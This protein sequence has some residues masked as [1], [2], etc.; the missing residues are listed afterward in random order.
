MRILVTGSDGPGGV[1]ATQLHNAGH[2]IVL[3]ENRRRAF[4]LDRH[5]LV[6]RSDLGNYRGAIR[7]VEAAEIF[8]TF[9]LILVACRAHD[10][11]EL[12]EALPRAVGTSTIIASLVTGLM[13]LDKLR[14]AFPTAT[15][16]DGI[17]DLVVL[18]GAD[19]KVT[20]TGATDQITL[21]A[22]KP[23]DLVTQIKALFD[24]TNLVAKISPDVAQI[25]WEC[26][27]R[28]VIVAGLAALMNSE[29]E[30]ICEVDVDATHLWQLAS[31]TSSVATA[32]G[33]ALDIVKLA[34]FME[35]LPNYVPVT[36][37]KV[38]SD[39]AN[40]DLG[41]IGTLVCEVQQ[42]ARKHNMPVPLL[43]VI[44]TATMARLPVAAAEK[45]VPPVLPR[46]RDSWF[47]RSSQRR[48]NGAGA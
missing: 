14:T 10:V 18:V 7:Y 26:V 32:A 12:I 16:I 11:D 23:N 44:V 27:A 29:M 3:L 30:R 21:S 39:V 25:R 48:K 9:E 47:S 15:V 24:T 5:A 28:L 34:K 36:V 17:H 33:H 13:H 35:R 41:E 22:A 46:P 38:L 40:G 1:I 45:A 8:S 42:F 6:L 19:G 31:E 37:N 20:H 4:Y 43:D 2:D